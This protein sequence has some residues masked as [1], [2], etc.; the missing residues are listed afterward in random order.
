MIWPD[1]LRYEVDKGMKSFG[2]PFYRGRTV[3][4]FM[5]PDG[6]VKNVHCTWVATIPDDWG[7]NKII[8]EKR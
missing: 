3:N 8:G 1:V 2:R 4:N 6:T 7:E 5:R